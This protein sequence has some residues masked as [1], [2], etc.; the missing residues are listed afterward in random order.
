MKT[1]SVKATSLVWDTEVYPREAI[2]S[3]NLRNIEMAIRAGADV[4]PII[5][6]K[7]TS[8]IVDGVHRWKA[9]RRVSG[10]DCMVT[11]EF[12]QYAN[13]Q[14]L[15]LDVVRC[16]RAHGRPYT[17][18][19]K[20]KIIAEGKRRR[21]KLELIAEALSLPKQEMVRRTGRMAYLRGSGEPVVLKAGFASLAGKT[22][23]K[24]QAEENQHYGGMPATY[25]MRQVISALRA[26]TIDFEDHNTQE[27]LTELHELLDEMMKLQTA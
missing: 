14:E 15:W 17:P 18:F 4:G 5:A 24:E 7:G 27:L 8:R 13:E 2:D 20:L 21:I 19:E 3:V 10:D 22:I 25:Y 26:K 16:N 23:T 9:H 11:V 12:R 6:E 1:T